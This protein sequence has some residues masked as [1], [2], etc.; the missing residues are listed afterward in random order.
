MSLRENLAQL[1]AAIDSDDAATGFAVCEGIIKSGEINKTV[2]FNV[3]ASYGYFAFKLSKLDVA[4]LYLF[5][6]S[7]LEAPVGPSQKNL[8]VRSI[9]TVLIWPVYPPHSA[10]FIF[11][12]RI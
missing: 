8:K 2:A 12:N 7:E 10:H 1:K 5:K 6:A 9:M 4:E 3:Y 11:D